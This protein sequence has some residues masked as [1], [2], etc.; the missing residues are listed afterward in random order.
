MKHELQFAGAR[1]ARVPRSA[2]LP[3]SQRPAGRSR[4]PGVSACF[5]PAGFSNYPGIAIQLRVQ[6]TGPGLAAQAVFEAWDVTL[7]GASPSLGR[8]ICSVP[9][10]VGGEHRGC[11]S[12][13]KRRRQSWW[14]QDPGAAKAPEPG[15]PLLAASAHPG[16]PALCVLRTKFGG[17]DGARRK[18]DVH[19]PF[20]RFPDE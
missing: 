5:L 11:S 9:P 8:W 13:G 15:R 2:R 12:C 1:G 14:L 17:S 18:A 16:R 4:D 7:L 3:C 19:S 6:L 10:A 20:V